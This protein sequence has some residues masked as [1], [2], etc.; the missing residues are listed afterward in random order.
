MAKKIQMIPARKELA[1][2]GL[3][4]LDKVRLAAYARVS[5]NNEDQLDSFENQV[6][7]YRDYAKS[8]PEYTLVDI[9]ADEGISGTSTR[10]RREFQRMIT[11]C[12][13][14]KIDMVITK[15]ISR[16]ARNTQDCLHFARK[17]KD[18]RIPIFFEKENIN[19]LDGTG[20]VL[21]TILSSLAQDESRSISE[22]CAW[23]IRALFKQGRLHL[24]TCHFMGY[25]K[26]DDGNLV[27]NEEQAVIVRRVF[28]EFLN[29]KGMDAI[30]DDLNSDGIPGVMGAPK[31]QVT[32]VKQML[33]NEKYMGD[34]LLQKSYVVDFLTGRSVPN[35]GELPQ[36]YIQDNHPP[37]ID[38]KTW[39]AVQQELKRQ[40]EFREAHSLRIAGRYT[41]KQPFS[42][43]VVCGRCNRIYQRRTKTRTT[44]KKI[45]WE[46]V[47]RYVKTTPC[48]S[49][50][51]AEEVLYRA[52]LLSWNHILST[53]AERVARWQEAITNGN[54]LS[55]LRGEQMLRLT[56]GRLP[57]S[58]FD[59]SI[60]SKVL[61]HI[62]VLDTHVFD[63][64]FLDGTSI[65]VNVDKGRTVDNA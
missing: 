65:R 2:R 16:F 19:T 54:E 25:D 47:S 45:E 6:A 64:H 46:C 57:S 24:N 40:N 5:T 53:R 32:T 31:W 52:F 50:S 42:C 11:D 4:V 48:H 18:L 23:G 13:L 58:V 34:A 20:E 21:F 22:N 26:D 15:S 38:K 43:K 44:G 28:D 49:C 63:V 51:V 8:H 1:N 3:Q 27:I 39:Y 55:A 61:D 12:E 60:V 9:Y 37:I 29:G 14:G 10:H 30:A 62:V 56:E 35:K 41:A 33:N 59:L 7:H 17:L 36:Y